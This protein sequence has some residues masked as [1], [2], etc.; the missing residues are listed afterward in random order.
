M[1]MEKMLEQG[2]EVILGNRMLVHIVDLC[3]VTSA[4]ILFLLLIRPLMKRLPRIGMY[5]L[6]F[7]V[8]VRI[9][10]P[11]TVNG[12][13]GLLP[14]K[15]EQSVGRVGSYLQV[16]GIVEKLEMRRRSTYGGSSNGYRL[17]KEIQVNKDETTHLSPE[18]EGV[19]K[20]PSLEKAASAAPAAAGRE[21]ARDEGQ[22][23][24]VL[25]QHQPG[26]WLLGIWGAGVLCCWLYMIFWIIRTHWRYSDAVC[27]RDNIYQHPLVDNSF[28]MGM[29]SPKIY[30]SEQ[31][32]GEARRYVL[33][34]EQ[35]HIAR[36]DYLV[37]PL[38][39]AVF[40]LLWFNPL[41][42]A[43]W[44]FMMKDMEIS[45][46]EAVVRKLG[47]QER[48]Y[49]SSLLISL[50]SGSKMV[51]SQNPGF[52]A[53]TVK[54]RILSVMRCRKPGRAVTI[55]LCAAVALCGCGIVSE[56]VKKVESIPDKQPKGLW[57]EKDLGI[58]RDEEAF[59]EVEKRL[60]KGEEN[61]LMQRSMECVVDAQGTPVQFVRL[62]DMKEISYSKFVGNG[63][64]GWN[65]VENT[66]SS[67]YQKRFPDRNYN[68]ERYKYGA[69]GFL[70]LY[71]IRYNLCK[72]DAVYRADQQKSLQA[73]EHYL[74]RV[75]EKEGKMVEMPVM[76]QP[77]GEMDFAVASDGTILFVDQMNRAEL[78]NGTTLEKNREFQMYQRISCV[79]A[80]DEFWTYLI[81]D[82]SSKKIHIRILD[83][84]GD[85][86]QDL[87]TEVEY[88]GG[89]RP[90]AALGIKDNT[91]IL[92]W[93]DGIYEAE[94]GEKKLR[95]ILGHET[96]N[97]YYLW[98]ELYGNIVVSIFKGN[99]DDYYA[100]MQ[101]YREDEIRDPAMAQWDADMFL[102]YTQIS[103]AE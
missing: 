17:P 65:K 90:P 16:E 70:Y 52:S 99:N 22:V 62:D 53:G 93:G 43:A 94:P 48:E 46:D 81:H 80:G 50:A 56:P 85:Q 9:L 78:Y 28:V 92:A 86:L 77:E 31:L 59:E 45:C 10:C 89:T 4:V 103:D 69:D 41:V 38:V 51:M 5:I 29:L 71:V 68:L 60:E 100:G 40:S 1:N 57:V 63:D 37:K 6:W 95:Y 32:I 47:Y 30:I 54:E 26:E 2:L 83:E 34:H 13:Y 11:V 23:M 14:D 97:I 42:W 91:V 55:I 74:L 98:S 8:L 12:I 61:P 21:K 25:R 96:D 101:E 102:H 82:Q 79:Y 84:D 24:D 20:T 27:I 49:Y 87:P 7:M 44:Y 15:I 3:A 36:R 76:Q 19:E 39:F 88:N 72:D 67:E 75:D 18:K 58:N 35:V 73:L 33:C 66:W 64:G